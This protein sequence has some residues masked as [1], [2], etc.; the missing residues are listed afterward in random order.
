VSEYWLPQLSF[1]LIKAFVATGPI[2]AGGG[3]HPSPSLYSFW[4]E[5]N[6]MSLQLKRLFVFQ[7]I[8]FCAFFNNK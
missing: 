7:R 5:G 4:K 6:L 2:L 1:G 8:D 3:T